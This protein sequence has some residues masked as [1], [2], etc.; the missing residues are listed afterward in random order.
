M[1]RKEIDRVLSIDKHVTGYKD[2]E[3]CCHF[4]LDRRVGFT[5]SEMRSGVFAIYV[6]LHS[7]YDWGEPAAEDKAEG[8]A[9]ED[10]LRV[11]FTFKRRYRYS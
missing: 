4:S 7:G 1:I 3:G 8:V 11:F 5:L 2:K 10:A 9:L 6:I